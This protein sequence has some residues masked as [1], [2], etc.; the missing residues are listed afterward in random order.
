[1]DTKMNKKQIVDVIKDVNNLK[2][3]IL[4]L[5]TKINKKLTQNETNEFIQFLKNLN[6]VNIYLK[7]MA[8]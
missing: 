2:K 4:L 6:I 7:T 8:I 5:E 1:M 3:I